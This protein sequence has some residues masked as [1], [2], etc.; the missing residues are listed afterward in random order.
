MEDLLYIAIV[1]AFF[2]IALAFQTYCEQIWVAPSYSFSFL[3]CSRICCT[4]CF[5]RKTS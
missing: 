3:Q 2:A 4:R 1:I 5:I